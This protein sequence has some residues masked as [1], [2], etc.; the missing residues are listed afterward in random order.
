MSSQTRTLQVIVSL[1]ALAF[2][3]VAGMGVPIL[4]T[5]N[6]APTQMTAKAQ[7]MIVHISTPDPNRPTTTPGNPIEEQATREA[8]ID[9]QATR[10]LQPLP[11]AYPVETI[12]F[13]NVFR[14][15]IW[16]G[17]LGVIFV[18]LVITS[19]GLISHLRQ[20]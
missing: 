9:L 6:S 11:T 2:M 19:L 14:A 4:L 15:D 16:L 13:S 10:L 1:L 3:F 20:H 18:L 17:A 5:P 8:Y 12:K 7:V